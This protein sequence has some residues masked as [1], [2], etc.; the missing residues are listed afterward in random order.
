[1][2]SIGIPLESLKPAI[3]VSNN[4]KDVKKI[5]RFAK[6]QA[7]TRLK[8]KIDIFLYLNNYHIEEHGLCF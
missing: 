7:K 4:R 1:M 6:E 3:I 8:K 5:W 2:Q